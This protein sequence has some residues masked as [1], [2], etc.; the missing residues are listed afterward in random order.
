MDSL[1]NDPRYIGKRHICTVKFNANIPLA[2]V[3]G[4]VP[5]DGLNRRH[6]DEPVEEILK[7]T[8]LSMLG[9]DFP[10]QWQRFPSY[11]RD[12]G[13]DKVPVIF[14][15]LSQVSRDSLIASYH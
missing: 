11:N 3:R 8:L 12:I 14:N 7:R 2:Q 5:L 6:S 10:L 13:N 9:A 15:A 1:A 4:Q